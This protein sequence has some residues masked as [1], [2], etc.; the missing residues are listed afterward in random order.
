MIEELE[1]L[2]LPLEQRMH[3]KFSHLLIPKIIFLADE[4][5]KN[6]LVHS[7]HFRIKTFFYINTTVPIGIQVR[8]SQF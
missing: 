8:H 6:R 1:K 2:I 4:I 3:L 7:F 5:V